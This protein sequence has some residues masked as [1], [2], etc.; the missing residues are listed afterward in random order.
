MNLSEVSAVAPFSAQFALLVAGG[1]G[2]RMG[3]LLPKQFLLL[4]G[5][6]VLLRT[7]RRFAAAAPAATCVVLLPA[8]EHARWQTLLAGFSEV[9]AHQVLAGGATRLA[10]VRAGL[11]A[12]TAA[13]A[14]AS[15]LVAIHDGVR[16]LVPVGVVQEAYRVAAAHGGAVAAVAL[17]DS[18]RRVR[19]DGTSVAEDRAALRLV[20]TPQCFPLGVLRAAYA[21]V[22]DDDPTLTDDASVVARAGYP[23]A[24]IAGAYENL[25]ITTPE[26]LVLAEALLRAGA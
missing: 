22:T 14:P 19:A 5:E 10:S 20:Q 15:A 25:K 18:V 24:L 26:D 8:T 7:L 4:L 2:Q 17:K 9:P 13:G 21:A 6:P 1:S 23:L 11:A 12:L 16:P 3:A